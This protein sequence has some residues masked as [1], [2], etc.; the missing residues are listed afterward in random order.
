VAYLRLIEEGEATGELAREYEAAVA[1]AGRVMNILKSMSLRP[2]VLPPFLALNR[3]I[4]FAP[5]ELDRVD[6]E[7]SPSSSRRQTA[8]ATTGQRPR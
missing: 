4:N 3:E 1:R 7:R 5:S 2:G 6:R 8:A